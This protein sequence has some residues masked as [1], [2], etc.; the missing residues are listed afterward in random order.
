MKK[1]IIFILILF[2]FLFHSSDVRAI[3]NSPDNNIFGIHIHDDNDLE[4]AAKLVNSNGGDWGYVTLVIRKDDRN[5]QKWQETFDKMRRL[6]LI[7]ILRIA[8]RQQNGGWEK[9]SFDE[10]DGWVLF[11]NNLNWVTQ[12]RFVIIGNEP[13][14]AKEWG[15][16]LNPEEYSNY[17]LEFSK[18]LKTATNEFFILPAGFDA[19]APTDSIHMDEAQ[20]IRRMFTENENVFEYIDGWSSHSYPNPNFSASATKTG[21]ISIKSYEW[22]LSLLKNLG[23]ERELPV[24]IT[25]TGWI[26]SKNGRNRNLTPSAVSDRFVTAYSDIWLKDE[27]VHAVTP[28]I[29]N[30]QETPFNIFSWKDESGEYYEFYYD[31]QDITKV[32]G[33]PIQNHSLKV[34]ALLL[35]KVFKKGDLYYGIA[36]AKNTGQSIWTEG[37]TQTIEDGFRFHKI[38]PIRPKTIEPNSSGII[39]ISENI[40]SS[41]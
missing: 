32:E 18:K 36:Y 23:F 26:H 13:N 15:N 1:I 37:F 33:K 19:S 17:L 28:F 2:V 39:Y 24:F 29:L 31:V 38:I 3:D 20:Y 35:P 9:P 27:R 6:H 10:I 41:E 8:T 16:E 14:H 25:E 4:D 30:Y 5:S 22:E 11:L 34:F 40:L 12:K 21:R 7:P